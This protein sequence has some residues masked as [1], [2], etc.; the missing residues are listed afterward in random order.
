MKASW[1]SGQRALLRSGK[2]VL[3]AEE[4]ER[5]GKT[6]REREKEEGRKRWSVKREGVKLEERKRRRRWRW[7]W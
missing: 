5:G 6:P 3:A 1:T 7:R 4:K 2:P